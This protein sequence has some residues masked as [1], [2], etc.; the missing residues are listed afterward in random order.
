MVE[1]LTGTTASH[2]RVR[3]PSASRAL[4]LILT[5]SVLLRVGVALTLGESLPRLQDD[6][7]YSLLATRL[8]GGHG[9]TFPEAWY[10]FTPADTPTAHWSFL[11]T[12]FL[13]GVYAIFG[14]H[15]LA[16]RLI[17]AVLGGLLLPWMVFRVTRALLR[18]QPGLSG[19]A[20]GH[21]HKATGKEAKKETR[22][23]ENK[24]TGRRG[25]VATR[26]VERSGIQKGRQPR[27]RAAAARTP[28]L[29]TP[30]SLLP[31]SSFLHS[32]SSAIPLLA[33][34]LAA[35]YAYFILYAARP[36]TETFY[37]V[38]VLW[39][40]DRALA[41][42]A[43]PQH[44][45]F[46]AVQL[47]LSLGIAALLRQSILPWVPVLFLWLL[48]YWWRDS[49]TARSNVGTLARW[50]VG[51]PQ[52]R[53]EG[54]RS[55]GQRPRGMRAGSRDSLATLG[56]TG[57]ALGM[58][59]GAPE[60]TAGGIGMTAGAGEMTAGSTVGRVE[61][62][63]RKEE[64]LVTDTSGG[65]PSQSQS[66][67]PLLPTPY[68]LLQSA[69]P[70]LIAAL[71]LAACIAPFTIRNA[72]VYDDFLLLNSNAGFA[73]YSAQHPMHGTRFD[74]HTAAPLPDD[75]RGRELSEAALDRELMRRGLGFV[76][77]EPGRY[78]LLSLSRVEDYVRF[79]PTADSPLLYDV[80]RVASFGLFL[81]F[82]IYGVVLAVRRTAAPRRPFV[83][84]RT[85][86]AQR[87]FA[88]GTTAAGAPFACGTSAP[89]SSTAG[90]RNTTSRKESPYSLLPTPYS[91]HPRA[92][93]HGLI[94]LSASPIALPLL[95]TAFYSLLHILTWAMIRYR[96]PVD[97]LGL[98][99]AAIGIHDLVVR[100]VG[101]S[102]GSA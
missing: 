52:E 25:D 58:T 40:M 18:L 8:A 88:H 78:V 23:Q 54:N 46:T 7:S 6:Y 86:A 24:G 71:V 92:I 94:Q 53:S 33:A 21:V 48:W 27:H 81:P 95:F 100:F 14:V 84:R 76:L 97:A 34:A 67:S 20:G 64:H 79:W 30:Y 1:A 37:I 45:L 90:T 9:F 47:G 13:A 50:H 51:S 59:G 29:P 3:R 28:L 68:S 83:A 12:A 80:G 101:Q 69:L 62:D 43:E 70:L 31:S 75:L 36:V 93:L 11:Y 99:F 44:R 57:G 49:S 102:G 10:P 73:M 22:I 17:Q 91:Q 82:M 87:A 26:K 2:T 72:I 85:F 5:V 96:L 98:I 32:P 39:S 65:T 63:A 74:E 89:V 35:L 41:L 56:M 42:V 19:V 77:E 16:A 55:S 38:A 60:M 61:A 15:P 4:A 66:E